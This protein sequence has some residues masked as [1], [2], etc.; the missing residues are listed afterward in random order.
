[1][2]LFPSSLM[3]KVSENKSNEDRISIA[4]NLKITDFN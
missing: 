4:F 2:L 1:M 3:H